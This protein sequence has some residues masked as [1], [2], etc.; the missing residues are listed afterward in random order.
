MIHQTYGIT[1]PQQQHQQSHYR[2]TTTTY[3]PP[4][5]YPPALQYQTVNPI[6]TSQTTYQPPPRHYYQ[7]YNN[8]QEPS[9]Q[10]KP[11]YPPSNGSPKHINYSNGELI[12][13]QIYNHRLQYQQAREYQQYRQTREQMLVQ[14]QSSGT[15]YVGGGGGGGGGYGRN[16]QSTVHIPIVV[17]SDQVLVNRKQ[18]EHT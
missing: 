13:Q 11:H 12:Q 3:I 1:Q 2:S 8:H 17:Q 9:Y 16:Y 14:Q 10:T 4:N 5:I 6:Y 18:Y 7:P 15:G